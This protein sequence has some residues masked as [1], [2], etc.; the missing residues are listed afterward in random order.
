MSRMSQFNSKLNTYQIA[1]AFDVILY[2]IVQP[3]MV[4]GI[5]IDI[6]NTFMYLSGS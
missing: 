3:N 5:D 2:V 4:P 6:E 1:F